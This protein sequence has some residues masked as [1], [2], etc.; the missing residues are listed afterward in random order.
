MVAY[1]DAPPTGGWGFRSLDAWK[2]I[3]GVNARLGV[4]ELG[5]RFTLHSAA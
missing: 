5:G 4:R 1:L 3:K 2:W